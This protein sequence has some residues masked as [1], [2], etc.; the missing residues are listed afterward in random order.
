[1]CPWRQSIIGLQDAVLLRLD[2]AFKNI[3][4]S[5]QLRLYLLAMWCAWPPNFYGGE[6][7]D[8]SWGSVLKQITGMRSLKLRY[9]HTGETGHTSVL[10]VSWL[11][12]EWKRGE[13]MTVEINANKSTASK[14]SQGRGVCKPMDQPWGRWGGVQGKTPLYETWGRGSRK[15]WGFSKLITL[16]WNE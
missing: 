16:G 2:L 9:P 3:P 13:N 8:W 12:C 5:Y 7:L 10:E 15:L 1:M 4:F 14:A 11:G 6:F